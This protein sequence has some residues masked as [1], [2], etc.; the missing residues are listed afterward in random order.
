[1]LDVMTRQPQLTSE[2]VGY[3][4]M[5]LQAIQKLYQEVTIN[6]YSGHPVLHLSQ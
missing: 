4:A 2:E 5:V 3:V 1:M 6:G